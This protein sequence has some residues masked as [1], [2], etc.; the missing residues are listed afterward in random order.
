M[1]R[2]EYETRGRKQTAGF[3]AHLHE[4]N[5]GHN[6]TE[7]YYAYVQLLTSKTYSPVM[8]INLT[9]WRTLKLIRNNSGQT[10]RKLSDAVG[11][12]PSSMTPII[13]FF[14][15]KKWVKRKKSSAN[16]SAYGIE[17]TQSGI[18][19]YD[20][21]QEEVSRTESKIQDLLGER[22]TKRLV[23]LLDRLQQGLDART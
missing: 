7:A 11:I 22:D 17:M 9:Q 2:I 16:R 23:K 6:L 5:V 21:I 8:T 10:Q 15:R 19:A 20:K 13:D 14:E 18:K 1:A 12:D 4:N 3:A